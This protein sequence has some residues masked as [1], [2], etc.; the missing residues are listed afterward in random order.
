MST[1]INRSR[2]IFRHWDHETGLDEVERAFTTLE[3][4]F[5]LCLHA[6]DTLLV[7][8]V[9]IEGQDAEGTRRVVTLIFQSVTVSNSDADGTL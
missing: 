6:T 2:V 8:R 7:D 1:H 9:V 3:D 5:T 4:L